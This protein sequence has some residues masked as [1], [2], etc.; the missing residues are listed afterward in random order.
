MLRPKD[1]LFASLFLTLGCGTDELGVRSIELLLAPVPGSGARIEDPLLAA[2]LATASGVAHADGI[3]RV[4]TVSA[5]PLPDPPGALE[6]QLRLSIAA[7]ERGGLGAETVD[8]EPTDHSHGA[9]RPEGLAVEIH[10]IVLSTPPVIDAAGNHLWTFA[11]T[12]L[13][14]RGVGGLRAATISIVAVP[15]DGHVVD[16]LTGTLEGTEAPA[17]EGAHEHGA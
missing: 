6:Y 8:V 5:G 7:E 15:S 12:E 4:G 16:V 13:H 1:I 11:P 9:L 2:A 10:E 14:G 3:E 17:A